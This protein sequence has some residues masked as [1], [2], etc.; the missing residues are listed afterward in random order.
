MIKV[1]QDKLNNLGE[2]GFKKLDNEPRGHKY[3]WERYNDYGIRLYYVYVNK[4]NYLR[5]VA[6]DS[7]LI[8]NK[9]Q[10]LLYDLT[11][12]EIIEKEH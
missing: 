9:L 12:D 3:I 4:N 5:I 1:K 2:Y 8:A 11:K 6:E 10:D 7:V